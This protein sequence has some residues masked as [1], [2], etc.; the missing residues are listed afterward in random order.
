MKTKLGAVCKEL[1]SMPLVCIKLYS[2][3]PPNV[4]YLITVYAPRVS[5]SQW[6]TI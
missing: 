5:G 3:R 4:S 1:S 6:G 2:K